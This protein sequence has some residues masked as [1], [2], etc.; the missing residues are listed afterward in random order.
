MGFLARMK[1]IIVNFRGGKHTQ[2]NDKMV[3][4]VEGCDNREAAGKLVGKTVTWK[5]PAGKELK[6]KIMAAHGNSGAVRANF[7]KGM[8]GQCVGKPCEVQ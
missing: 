1:A 5:S 2:K 8:P 3:I 7:E 6:G 4:Q